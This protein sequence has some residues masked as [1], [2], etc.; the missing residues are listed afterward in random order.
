MGITEGHL[1]QGERRE[2]PQNIN[3]AVLVSNK[4]TGSNLRAILG[5]QTQPDFRP[6]V[7]LV[8]AD[9]EDAAGIQ[10]AKD[11]KI[12]H[13]VFP[14][15]RPR[16]KSRE[17]YRD[18]YSERV[19]QTLNYYQTDLSVLAGFNRILTRPYFITFKGITLNIHPGA[20][21]DEKNKPFL[22][23]D[24]TE[25]PWNQGMMT[26][27]AVANFLP[28]KYAASSIH[29]V[30]E[31]AD[32]GPVLKRPVIPVEDG[33]TV[34]TLYARLKFAEHKALLEVLTN[35]PLDLMRR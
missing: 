10:I 18:S 15:K 11:H 22:F 32:F 24:G 28:L 21:P 19:G 30:T 34:G 29:V 27:D 33:D 17:E 12:P 1:G 26:D 16:D 7:G 9:T 4:G 8:L 25:A 14:Y 13:E 3:L 2:I 20:I 35:P 31:E 23:P 6:R 5:A